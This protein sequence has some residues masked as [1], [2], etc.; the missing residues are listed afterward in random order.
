MI[1]VVLEYTSYGRFIRCRNPERSGLPYDRMMISILLKKW[2][3]LN[4]YCGDVLLQMIHIAL[5][6]PRSASRN[7]KKV[8]DGAKFSRYDRMMTSVFFKMFGMKGN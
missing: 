2:R 6:E 1:L 5:I 3:G 7:I 8:S 4:H